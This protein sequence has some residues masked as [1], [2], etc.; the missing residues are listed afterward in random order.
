[1]G[2][3]ADWP[4]ALGVALTMS[5]MT[6]ASA[7]SSWAAT[8]AIPE[9]DARTADCANWTLDGYHLGMRGD[10][11]L[12]VR[13][14]TLHVEGQAQAIEPGRFRGVLVLDALNSLKKWDAI[15]QTKD[16]TALRA[17]LRERFGEPASDVSGNLSDGDPGAGRQHRTIWW[18]PSCDAALIVYENS[19]G[20]GSAERMVSATLVRASSLPRG[21]IQSKTLF[22]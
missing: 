1:M 9:P 5:A 16:G 17:E 19:T 6:G 18:S 2:R 13:S 12:A 21:L 4:V 7:G 10:E 15:Y 22:P 3:L 20:S 8:L 11:L 14:L